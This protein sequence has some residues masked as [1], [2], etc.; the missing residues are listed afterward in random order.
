MHMERK[1]CC[2]EELKV[3]SKWRQAEKE[4]ILL[5]AKPNL[6][7]VQSLNL[8]PGARKLSHLH[9][10]S[11]EYSQY[12][13]CFNQGTADYW[14]RPGEGW[15]LPTKQSVMVMS[16]PRYFC[17]PAAADASWGDPELWAV[18]GAGIPSG[19]H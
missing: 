10:S 19:L 2:L 4:Q 3:E 16:S 8:G 14:W 12:K 7:Q 9:G 6:L 13:A 1:N 11:E 15:H 17:S 5:L 18:W